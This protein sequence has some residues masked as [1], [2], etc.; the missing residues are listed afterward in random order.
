MMLFCLYEDLWSSK[1]LETGNQVYTLANGDVIKNVFLK[2]KFSNPFCFLLRSVNYFRK[3]I[4]T[5]YIY[6]W[7]VHFIVRRLCI[8]EL[9][10]VF[11]S[12]LIRVV[13][14][15]FTVNTKQL[16]I[17][18]L[19]VNQQNTRSFF[20]TVTPQQTMLLHVS[21]HKCVIVRE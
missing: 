1:L 18:N 8:F 12:F 21:I 6:L 20:L 17:L 11:F 15:T 7:T 13:C 14:L 10:C 16:I 3:F 2:E 19:Q 9:W 5:C 4:K